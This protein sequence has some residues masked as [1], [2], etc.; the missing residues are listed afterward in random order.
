MRWLWLLV[1]LVAP[2]WGQTEAPLVARLSNDRVEVTT[3]FDGSSIL[4]FGSTTQPIGPGGAEILIVT[5]GPMDTSGDRFTLAM[6][7]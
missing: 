1:A 4:V 3:T 6:E 7:S 2:A 5:S